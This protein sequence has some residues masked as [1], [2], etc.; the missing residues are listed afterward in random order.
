M[1]IIK[2]QIRFGILFDLVFIVENLRRFDLNFIVED[3][4]I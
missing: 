3:V 4:F 2:I 1:G